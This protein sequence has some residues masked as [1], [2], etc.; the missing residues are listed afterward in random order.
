MKVPTR[1]GLAGAK[2]TAVIGVTILATAAAAPIA[3]PASAAATRGGPP[4]G[5]GHAVF[6]QTDGT[7]GNQVVAY[8]RAANGT[9][10]WAGA[11]R[12]GG[13]GGVRSG[14]GGGHPASPG[15]ARHERR[16]G[17]LYAVNA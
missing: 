11:Y 6:V 15:S 8:D 10:S 7:S 14:S 9:L 3:G 13:L 16:H 17:L 12:T 2:A 4:P 1:L 5:S